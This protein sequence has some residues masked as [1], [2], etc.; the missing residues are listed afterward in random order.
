M[1]VEFQPIEK[2]QANDLFTA[3][4]REAKWADVVGTLL[5]GQPV[6][7]PGM[8]RNALESLRSI[9]NYRK[10]GRLRSRSTEVEGVAGR[11]LKVQRPGG[12]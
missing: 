5:S 3:L 7:I 11:I 4:P 12:A 10:Y 8:S 6:F 1:A 9:I 2:R